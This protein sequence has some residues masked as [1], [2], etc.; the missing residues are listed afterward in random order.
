MSNW[1]LPQTTSFKAI[2]QKNST[3]QWLQNERRESWHVL[4]M[5]VVTLKKILPIVMMTNKL[6]FTSEAA[7]TRASKM[8]RLSNSCI[9]SN[10]RLTVVIDKL[11]SSQVVVQ[12]VNTS[13]NGCDN[14]YRLL[15]KMWK[16]R[17]NEQLARCDFFWMRDLVAKAEHIQPQWISRR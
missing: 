6:F 10:Q 5:M 16:W 15:P 7:L 17:W 12:I 11:L 4:Q 1:W 8:Q 3:K 13:D 2:L 9:R 14:R